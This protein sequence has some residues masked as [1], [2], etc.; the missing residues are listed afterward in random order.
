PGLAGKLGDDRDKPVV[1]EALGV[2]R[3]DDRVARLDGL[4]EQAAGARRIHRVGGRDRLAVKAAKLLVAH[5]H[6]GLDYRPAAAGR[7]QKVDALLAKYA[8]QPGAVL[9]VANEA[10]DGAL[11]AEGGDVE[12]DVCGATPRPGVPRDVDDRNGRLG[13]DPGGV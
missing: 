6:A 10:E 12:G 9:V 2:V 7:G 11:C 8:S 13:R 1:E 3:E 4:S 5:K